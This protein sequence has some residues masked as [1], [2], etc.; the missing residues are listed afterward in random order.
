MQPEHLP[1]LRAAVAAVL[2]LV[3]TEVER[4]AAAAP[5]RAVYAGESA[6]FARPLLR[7]VS[8]LADG[9]DRLA[10]EEGL[11]F[12][13]RL[14]AALPFAPDEYEQDFDPPGREQFRA[15]LAR[16]APAVL[17]LDGAHG[18]LRDASY[19]AVGRLVGRNCDLLIA[20]WDGAPAAGRGGTAEIVQFA[21]RAGPP[22]WWIRAD[23]S[24]EPTLI[25]D[26]DDL[27]RPDPAQR[28]EPAKALAR[29]IATVV[30]PPG[31]ARVPELLS[32]YFAGRPPPGNPLWR[33]HRL[34]MRL[35]SWPPH[36]S[37]PAPELAEPPSPITDFWR[38]H[39]APAD[40]LSVA[41]RDRYRSSYVLVFALAGIALICAVLALGVE[42]VRFGATCAEFVALAMIAL[43]VWGNIRRRWHQRWMDYRLL[44]ELCRKQEALALFGWRLPAAQARRAVGERAAHRAEASALEPAPHSAWVRWCFDAL[45]RAAP[46]P[47]DALSGAALEQ[48]RQIVRARLIG[49][50]VEYH[51]A[52]QADS[53]TASR[54]LRA[55]ALWSFVA[56]VLLVALKLVLLPRAAEPAH[57]VG[58]ITAILPAISAAA[59]GFRTYA[60][61]EINARESTRMEAV[62]AAAGRRIEAMPLDHPLASQELAAEVFA[63]ANEMLRDIEGWEHLF[64]VKELE[65]P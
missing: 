36:P 49:G 3:R 63:L 42:S 8:P 58:M 56:T 15:L 13:Y 35:L 34:A 21:A 28:G 59:F 64:R 48:A 4:L 43:L 40:T 25:E 5:A 6:T 50:Q 10:A 17:A 11:R 23:G 16:A 32:D 44:A 46:L 20:I 45:V 47:A 60:E 7:L 24:G 53:E 30:L 54:R 61:L 55:L 18:A 57:V 39:Y 65:A 37:P 38:R 2:E 62:M 27:R 31:E 29:H 12:G 33:A 9:A 51:R 1:A 41:Y 52:R 26:I 22:V 19:E 14:E